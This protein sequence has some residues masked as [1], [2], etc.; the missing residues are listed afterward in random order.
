MV[1]A[2]RLLSPETSNGHH[3]WC[4]L[5]VVYDAQPQCIHARAQHVKYSLGYC[6]NPKIPFLPDCWFIMTEQLSQ[7]Q[8]T[9][10]LKLYSMN[11]SAT[12]Y[13]CT[14]VGH[15]WPPSA[16]SFHVLQYLAMNL[17]DMFWH[18]HPCR[19]LQIAQHLNP[20]AS[21]FSLEVLYTSMQVK[22]CTC[23]RLRSVVCAMCFRQHRQRSK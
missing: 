22:E 4:I 18:S 19:V 16:L 9:N 7:M 20:T 23:L 3:Q 15:C 1:P 14:G 13:L 12:A 8:F 5:P 6:S 10:S 17:L 21:R 11:E 2:A